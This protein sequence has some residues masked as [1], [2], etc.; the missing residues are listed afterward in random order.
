MMA[1]SRKTRIAAEAAYLA[2][3]KVT[4]SNYHAIINNN[5]YFISLRNQKYDLVQVI[6][7]TR[8]GFSAI[9]LVNDGGKMLIA[10][11][12]TDFYDLNILPS[13][14]IVGNL[15]AKILSDDLGNDLQ[16]M[17]GKI[18]RQ[19][20]TA[21]AFINSLCEHCS[22]DKMLLTGHSLG[23][24]LA[25]LISA[26]FNIEAIVFDS[27][28]AKKL[29]NKL[30]GKDFS[31]DH[32][33]IINDLPNFVNTF[34]EQ[35]N[36]PIALDNGGT[37]SLSMVKNFLGTIPRRSGKQIKYLCSHGMEDILNSITLAGAYKSIP[38]KTWPK[39]CLSFYST[40]EAYNAMPDVYDDYLYET[41]QKRESKNRLKTNHSSFALYKQDFL[42]HKLKSS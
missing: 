13:T 40:L 2:S 22:C 26:K 31:S 6:N 29:I 20:E 42:K 24:L 33:T 38:I 9:A 32:I 36:L 14:G 16:I 23:A 30:V 7:N 1:S 12:G 41:W 11:R 34:G 3:F 10:F 4:F 37:I 21:L 18:P 19:F 28:G 5:T 35:V 25:Q 17:I 15:T 8:D 39:K 27:P